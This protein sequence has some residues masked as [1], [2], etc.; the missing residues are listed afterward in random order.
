MASCFNEKYNETVW[1]ESISQASDMIAYWTS[2]PSIRNTADDLRT[3][4]LDVLCKAGFAKSF[5]FEGHEDV[6]HVDPSKSYKDSLQLILENCIL[7][8]AMGTGFFTKNSWLPQKYRKIGKAITAFQNFVKEM[9]EVE[10]SK[11]AKGLSGIGQNRTFLSLLAK[12]SLEAED[13]QVLTEEEI[14]GNIFVINFA[15]HD[16]SSHVFT[17]AVF[18]LAA[19]PDVQD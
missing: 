16:T 17:F 14:Y 7:I 2:R 5:K 9:Y 12:A 15:G 3:L 4:S 8:I 13:G 1:S 18:F 11:T 6:T 19:N 10:K